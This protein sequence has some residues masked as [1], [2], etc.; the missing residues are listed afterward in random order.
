MDADATL[1]KNSHEK[2]FDS[3][4]KGD[5]DIL[6]GTQMVAKGLNF[7]NVTLVGVVNA[8]QMLY[9]DD[10]KSFERA[11]SLLTQVV[12]RSGR[13]DTKGRA[14]IQTHTP[15]SHVISL[16]ALQ[17]YDAFYESEI[18]LRQAML[19]PPFADL[20]IAGF[21]AEQRNSAQKGAEEF[22][23]LLASTAKTKFPQLPMRVL[24]P[25][26]EAVAKINNKYRYRLMIKCR[27]GKD[28]RSL[29]QEVLASFGTLP[30]HK[31]T[32]VYIDFI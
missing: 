1:R 24:G 5:Y 25:T 31:N 15:E 18:A 9:A 21:A 32:G 27:S 28:F 3:F 12:G 4:L 7:P 29:M 16:A 10:Y 20:C 19:Y 6:I 17:D 22:L 23:K 2:L 14:I 8:D 11:F 26:L 30:G 13:G